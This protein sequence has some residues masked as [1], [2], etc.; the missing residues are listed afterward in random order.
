MQSSREKREAFPERVVRQKRLLN[1]R[2][3]AAKSTTRSE[4]AFRLSPIEEVA[5]ARFN[6]GVGVGVGVGL[7]SSSVVFFA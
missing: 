1:N 2:G 6:Y 3:F 7:L 4:N 5:P